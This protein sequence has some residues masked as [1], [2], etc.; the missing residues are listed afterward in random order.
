MIWMMTDLHLRILGAPPVSS[1][2]EGSPITWPTSKTNY[3]TK[4]SYNNKLDNDRHFKRETTISLKSW[5]RR[6]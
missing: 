1:E 2:G 5:T 4:I 6:L 3:T